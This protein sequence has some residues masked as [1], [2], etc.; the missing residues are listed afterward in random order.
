MIENCYGLEVRRRGPAIYPV[1]GSTVLPRGDPPA[2]SDVFMSQLS[3]P[4]SIQVEA[5]YQTPLCVVQPE[6]LS[7]LDYHL[8][9]L[10]LGEMRPLPPCPLSNSE[11]AVEYHIGH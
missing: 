8:G 9:C 11:S 2:M 5:P 3:S 1:S 10:E 4:M 7:H 6:S